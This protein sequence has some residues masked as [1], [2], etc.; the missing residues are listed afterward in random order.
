M[1]N[2]RLN[3]MIL[4]IKITLLMMKRTIELVIRMCRNL[5]NLK[6]Y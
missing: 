3:F 6:I 2:L 4:R 5:D 1:R